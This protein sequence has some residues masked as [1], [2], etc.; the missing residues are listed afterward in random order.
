MYAWRMANI[1]QNLGSAHVIPPPTPPSFML[2]VLNASP[3]YRST[4]LPKPSSR[5]INVSHHSFVSYHSQ[6]LR[7]YPLVRPRRISCLIPGC[8]LAFALPAPLPRLTAQWATSV[9]A[10]VKRSVC[11]CMAV[12]ASRDSMA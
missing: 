3:S 4:H 1:S 12:L 9:V 2:A 5:A 10:L 11:M 7:A 6:V 8:E